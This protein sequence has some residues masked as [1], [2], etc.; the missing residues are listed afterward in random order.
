MCIKEMEILQIVTVIKL[1]VAEREQFLSY[2]FIK[3]TPHGTVSMWPGLFL[4]FSKKNGDDTTWCTPLLEQR[5]TGTDDILVQP[6]PL[7]CILPEDRN[8]VLLGSLFPLLN[9]VPEGQ[10]SRHL[11]TEGLMNHLKTTNVTEIWGG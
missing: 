3:P 5:C 6:F 2:E 10:H 7:G 11:V 1:H 9:T 8:H 4:L